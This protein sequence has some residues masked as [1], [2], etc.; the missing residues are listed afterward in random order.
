MTRRRK[1]RL[2]YGT[3]LFERGRA[4]SHNFTNLMLDAFEGA[5]FDVTI[6]RD[7]ATDRWRTQMTRAHSITDASKPVNARSLVLRRA[8]VGA[9]WRL[10]KTQKRWEFD[11]AQD[12]FDPDAVDGEAAERFLT[13]WQEILF[14][15]APRDARR[16]GFLLVPLQAKLLDKRS[17]QAMAPIQMV[18]AIC[19]DGPSKP[20]VVTLHPGVQYGADE[21]AALDRL[22]ERHAR[23]T[24][25][26]SA[27]S[28][29]LRT[30]DAVACQN[31]AVAF[32]GYF[33]RK[34][35]ILF[36][37]IDFH[38]IAA[39]VSEHGVVGAFEQL[40]AA[41]PDF[42][43]YLFWFL[44]LNAIGGGQADAPQQILAAARRAGW[45]V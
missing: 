40:D 37:E 22:L 14:G 8:Y 29:L 25:S 23:L 1:L 31:S 3:G 18:D 7:R 4:G 42:A 32:N 21:M 12:V 27:S 44:R 17:F 6:C 16:G 5:G 43:R 13:R 38:H 2:H 11:V 34:P 15:A 26:Q 19:R 35:A 28:D 36:A 45:D 39:R 41:R 24:V 20:V 33:F 10:E 30:C 9:F